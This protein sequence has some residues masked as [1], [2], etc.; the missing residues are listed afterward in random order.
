MVYFSTSAFVL[1]ICII[2]YLFIIRKS[3]FTLH[4]FH[5]AKIPLNNESS[6]SSKKPSL[7][8]G[9]NSIWSIFKIISHPAI[10][11]SLNFFVT[12]SL[13]PGISS[14]L[15]SQYESI[16][17]ENW[18]PII[19]F[20]AFNLFDFVGRTIPR[21]IVIFNEKTLWILTLLRF[22]FFP[23]FVLCLKPKIFEQDF[24]M[25]LFMILFSLSNGYVGTLAMM[26]GPDLV[27]NQNKEIA[28]TL[29]VFFLTF[30]LTVGV[31]T[32]TGI[33][34]LLAKY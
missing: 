11:V 19:L 20:T 13:F 16:N 27:N 30:G 18:Y 17:K 32:G 1:L 29:M 24:W 10:Q 34:Y 33:D 31:W 23:L 3:L 14:Q 12:L 7:I 5:I 26:F 8:H 9:P 21:W 2:A 28:G 4:Y 25:Y 22:I 6:F 15:T